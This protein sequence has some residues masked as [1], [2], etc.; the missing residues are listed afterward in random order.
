MKHLLYLL[1]ALTV[2]S[3]ANEPKDYATFSGKITDKNSDSIVIRSRQLKYSKT[4]AVNEDGTFSDTL[5]VVAGVYSFY[6]GGE[7]TSIY[8]KNGFDIYMTLDTK[9][10][11]ESASYTGTGAE[12]SNF[13]AANSLKMESLLDKPFGDLNKEELTSVFDQ[14]KKELSEFVAANSN[15][16]TL[17]TNNTV[18]TNE[19]TIASYMNYYGGIL[20]LRAK[21]NGQ[22]SPEFIDYMNVNGGTTSLS[23]LK[24]QYVY[25]DVWASWCGPC[26]RE[27]P[28][29][30]EVEKKYHDKNIAFVSLSVDDDRRSGTWEKAEQDWRDMIAEKE[31]GGIQ[32]LSPKGWQSDFVKGYEI[33]GIPRFILIGPD[34]TILDAS[35]PRPSDEALISLFD[36]YEI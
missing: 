11:D 24:G 31:L 22:P 12:H 1:I 9:E 27:I 25:V 18:K 16:D 14:A 10:F 15:I 30:K 32:V 2:I 33:N 26:K 6:D 7:S 4:I 20:D 21:L 23:D 35:A 19:S 28:F 17:V 13:L 5:K 29:L 8:L 36:R 34:G 3:C